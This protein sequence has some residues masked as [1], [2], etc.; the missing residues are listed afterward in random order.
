MADDRDLR[1]RLDLTFPPQFEGIARGIF[2]FAQQQIGKA[3][4]INEGQDN[5]ER[6]FVDF[7]RCGHRLGLP[8]DKLERQEVE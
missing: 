2:T 7:V 6:G 4:V 8:C 1:V 3:V 5:E